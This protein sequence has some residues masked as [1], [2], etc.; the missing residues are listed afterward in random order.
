MF[1]DFISP[2]VDTL[3]LLSSRIAHSN[4][5]ALINFSIITLLSYL[6]ATFIYLFNSLML[7]AIFI[8]IEEPHDAGLI[9]TGNSISIFFR[10]LSL[11]SV[12]YLTC[13]IL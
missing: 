5:L 4:S 13:G 1:L 12:I 6:K 2:I 11:C 8:P 7:F 9:I 10:C 3:I